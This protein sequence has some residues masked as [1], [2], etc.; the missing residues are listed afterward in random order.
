MNRIAV[1]LAVIGLVIGGL[2]GY[3]WW[4]QPSRRLNQELAQ[5]QTKLGDATRTIEELSGKLKAAEQ[6]IQTLGDELKAERELRQRYEGL[7]G[8]G[9]K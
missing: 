7:V 3:L 8:R 9:R 6:Q 4:G 2:V 1:G 5:V